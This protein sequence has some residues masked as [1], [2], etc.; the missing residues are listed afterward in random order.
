MKT[1]IENDCLIVQSETAGA[2]LLSIRAKAD[3]SEYLWHGDP[4]YWGRTAP[5]LFPVVGATAGGIRVG[6]QTYPLKQHGFARDSQFDLISITP[7]AATYRMT[8][9]EDTLRVFPFRFAFDVGYALKDNTV[10]VSHRVVNRGDGDMFFSIGAHPAFL[11]P[12]EPGL[13]YEDYGLTFNRAETLDRGFINL[14]TGLINGRTQRVLDGGTRVALDAHSF[15]EGAWLLEGYASDAVTL[16]AP[17]GQK[18]V[19]VRFPGWPYLGLWAPPGAPHAAQAPLS[20]CSHN[21]AAA[22]SLPQAG[23][24]PFVCIEPW[25]GIADAEG[26]A[27]DISEKKGIIK[28]AAG[29]AFDCAYDIEIGI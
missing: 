6:G 1:L 12:L 4:K 15:D 14:Q 8:D 17:G 5:I 29:E 7:S 11:C 22:P 27:G 18:S 20:S 23:A 13:R 16:S 3:G 25:L 9:N 19:T 28:L 21:V 24:A 2:Q 26:F 10:M